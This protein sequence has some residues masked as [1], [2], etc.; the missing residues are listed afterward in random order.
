MTENTSYTPPSYGTSA[1]HCP[2][3]GVYAHQ[4]WSAVMDSVQ[5]NVPEMQIA[6]C[7]H[8]TLKRG[9]SAIHTFSV[10]YMQKMILP[11]T[12]TV[13]PPN[14]DLNA[15]II[16][17]YNEARSIVNKSPRGAAALLRICLELLRKQ[18]GQ[19]ERDL[20]KSIANLVA[21]GMPAEIQQALDIV[22]VIGNKMLHPPGQIVLQDS[23]EIATFLFQAVNRIA[24]VMITQRKLTQ[25][26]F[27]SL[28]Q[29]SLDQIEKRDRP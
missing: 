4:R 23:A 9:D 25:Q 7:E 28:P 1:F 18:L 5:H 15:D 24:D 20:N 11:D 13:A 3:C 17:I 16:D 2:N 12:T 21:D 27:D 8:C 6:R 19:N 29:D 22:R 14:P 26:F 10:W